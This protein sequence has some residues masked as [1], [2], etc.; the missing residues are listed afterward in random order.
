MSNTIS[1]FSSFENEADKDQILGDAVRVIESDRAGKTYCECVPENRLP[2]LISM[3]NE[4]HGHY[5]DRFEHGEFLELMCRNWLTKVAVFRA[6][7]RQHGYEV[8]EKPIAT[9]EE[10]NGLNIICLSRSAS[11]TWIGANCFEKNGTKI[12]YVPIPL[13]GVIKKCESDHARLT[14]IPAIG[15]AVYFNGFGYETASMTI[16]LYSKPAPKVSEGKRDDSE[17]LTSQTASLFQT[18]DG[19]TFI[20]KN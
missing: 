1:S 8:R 13:R 17:I 4:Y 16:E 15:N 14:R 18:I 7:C 19:Y 2:H 11:I 9:E 20:K 5:A 3:A 6:I 10:A 12:V